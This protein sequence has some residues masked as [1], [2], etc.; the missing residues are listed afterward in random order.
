[1]SNNLVLF[2][3]W[4]RDARSYQGLL[5]SAPANWKI[6]IISYEE[7]IPNGKI[8]DFDENAIKFLEKNNLNK[9]N[10]MGHSLGGALALEFAYHHPQKVQKLYLVDSEGIYEQASLPKLVANFFKSQSLY[11][12]KKSL[13]NIKALYR[14]LK[15]PKLHYKLAHFAHHANLQEEAKSI[16]VPTIILWGE[17]DHLTPLWQGQK[18]HDLINGSKFVILKGMDHDWVLHSPELF[19]KNI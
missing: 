4:S 7:L 1:M 8:D 6:F 14:A 17:Q 11:G 19:W 13:E 10:L 18:L 15:N 3:G 2:W 16:K 5:D 12:K 9:F